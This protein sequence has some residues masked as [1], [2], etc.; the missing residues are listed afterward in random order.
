M[1]MVR[2]Q[3]ILC[4]LCGNNNTDFLFNAIDRLHGCEGTFIYVKCKSCGLVYMN[5][6]ISPDAIKRF[7]PNDYS[8]HCV[9]EKVSHKSGKPLIAKIKNIRKSFFNNVKLISS[10][11]K[12]LTP[13][14][15]FLDVGCG[16]GSFLNQMKN[17]T[18]CQVDG[19]DISSK[20]IQT[21]KEHYGI[22]IFQGC[23]TE[24]PFPHNSFDVIT[25]WWS[26]EHVTNPS[27]VLRKMACLLKND[28]YCVIGVPNINSFNA[29]LFKDK[30]YHLDC[31]RHL[32]LYSPDT[33]T[34]LLDKAGFIVEKIIFDKTPKSFLRSLQY[35]FSNENTPLKDQKRFK[36]SSTIK[37]LWGPLALLLALLKQSDQMVVYARKNADP[38]S[39]PT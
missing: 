15:R 7:Y 13:Q 27:Q 16:N 24:A 4:D 25:S 1:N 21:A 20:A 32:Y 39:S 26:L 8:P 35:Y 37:R 18:C 33:I 28:G 34:R 31:P 38:S 23:I 6:Q 3:D 36:G 5:P 2:T 12:K 29:K 30:W 9:K 10:V 14:S 19:I 22:N 17:D 11:R